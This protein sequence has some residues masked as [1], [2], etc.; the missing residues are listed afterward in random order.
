M[1]EI[2]GGRGLKLSTYV[3]DWADLAELADHLVGLRNRT[4]YRM[5]WEWVD[6]VV[7][8]APRAETERLLDEFA[9]I[10]AEG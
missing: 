5:D 3:G 7:P 8:V 9:R 1:P 10:I 2:Q 4:D 6:H